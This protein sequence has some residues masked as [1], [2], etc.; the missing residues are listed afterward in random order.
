MRKYAI[1]INYA[2]ICDYLEYVFEQ[3]QLLSFET[4]MSY[5]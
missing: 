5:G 4:K 3:S 1:F 2:I